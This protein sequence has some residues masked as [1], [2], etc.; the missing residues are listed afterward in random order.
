[1]KAF[2]SR[3]TINKTIA[4][5]LVFWLSGLIFLF[6]CEMPKAQAA[7][8]DSCPLAKKN[9]C[10][11]ESNNEISSQFALFQI[12][13]QGLACCRI[14]PNIF[15]KARKI[16]SNPQLAESTTI[17]RISLP[18]FSVVKSDFEVPEFYQPPVLNRGGT[19]LKNRVFRI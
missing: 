14:L 10:A 19:Y 6:C 13:N 1:M 7:E 2:L 16:E 9:H 11:K 15:D 17:V 12:G 3:Q 5:T 18:R 8:T 4:A